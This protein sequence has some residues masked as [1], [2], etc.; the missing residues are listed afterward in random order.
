MISSPQVLKALVRTEVNH[1][2]FD[3]TDN[4]MCC[5]CG[6][7][8]AIREAEVLFWV[9]ILLSGLWLS[10]CGRS[11]SRTHWTHQC[12]YWQYNLSQCFSITTHLAGMNNWCQVSTNIHLARLLFGSIL[13]LKAFW[14][15]FMNKQ[16]IYQFQIEASCLFFDILVGLCM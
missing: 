15:L 9:W 10:L 7:S 5:A 11:R 16:L 12:L 1:H 3:V 13:H 2:W 6:E 4:T 14:C 8:A